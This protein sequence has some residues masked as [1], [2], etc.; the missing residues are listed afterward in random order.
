MLYVTQFFSSSCLI[1]SFIFATSSASQRDEA[2][3]KAQTEFAKLMKRK[4]PQ[5]VYLLV[6]APCSGKFTWAKSKKINHDRH[7]VIVDATNP[8]Q[9]DRARWILQA[10]KS[11]SVKIC[12]VMFIIS[13]EFP[14][15][16]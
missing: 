13:T 11:N 14:I 3:K 1:M 15:V 7:A 2:W 9:G 10:S 4:L 5:R 8:T 6:G 12:V 16:V